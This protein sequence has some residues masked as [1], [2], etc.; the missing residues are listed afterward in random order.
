[1]YVLN[2]SDSS[3]CWNY[4]KHTNC[5]HAFWIIYVTCITYT[6]TM[7]HEVML[8][9]RRNITILRHF[10]Q[11]TCNKPNFNPNVESRNLFLSLKLC[12]TC[13]FFRSPSSRIQGLQVSRKQST[14]VTLLWTQLSNE[15]V[16]KYKIHVEVCLFD[17]NSLFS[18]CFS[19]WL[20]KRQIVCSEFL[21]N[22]NKM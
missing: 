6:A 17:K 16:L 7:F 14:V 4:D 8:Y 1:M 21:I 11:Y 9:E 18:F 3:V 10:H 13:V 19:T 2:L 22:R 20:S 15:Y 12:A 5:K